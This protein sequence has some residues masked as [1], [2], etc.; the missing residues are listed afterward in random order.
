MEKRKF[1]DYISK[2]SIEQ[3]IPCFK[4]EIKSYS[5]DDV[6]LEYESTEPKNVAILADGQAKLEMIDA[7][8]DVYL[9]DVYNSNDVFGE[10]FSLPVDD[11]QYVVTASK[12]CTVIFIDYKHLT[13]PCENLCEHH[14][15]MISNLFIMAAQKTQEQSLHLSLL[16]QPTIRDK[17]MAYLKYMSSVEKS[18]E[19]TLPITL[20]EL[21]EYLHIDRASMMRA[22]RSLKD[23]G[24]I[25]SKARNFKMMR[26]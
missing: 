8:G 6:I 19:F 16:F 26:A 10:L 7:N 18:D 13:T 5:K 23:E 11:C 17:L 20:S 3:I 25:E 22:L 2:D 9:M 24:L 21:A 4:P 15:Q 1:F 12:D 14:N